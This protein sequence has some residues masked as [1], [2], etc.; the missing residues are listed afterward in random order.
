MPVRVFIP[1]N[2]EYE[3]LLCYKG[4][5]VKGAPAFNTRFKHHDEVF[6]GRKYKFPI[7]SQRVEKR[8]PP[9]KNAEA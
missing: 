2:V 8:K 9:K 4:V 5:A 1:K 6:R 3:T 7:N